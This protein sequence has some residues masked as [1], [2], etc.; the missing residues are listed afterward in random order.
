[1][2]LDIDVRQ[3]LSDR[4]V[5]SFRA[6]HFHIELVDAVL[7]GGGHLAGR[8]HR[9]RDWPGGNVVVRVRCSESWRPP[10]PRAPLALATRRAPPLRWVEHALW[11]QET[12]LGSLADAHWVPFDFELPEGLPPALEARSIAWR[13][14]IEARRCRRLRMSER[15]LLTPLRYTAVDRVPGHR[16]S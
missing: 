9:D 3:A 2:T 6:R 13:Y 12:R 7:E 10:L 5:A 14:E 1:V 16:I 8:V 15:A 11:E 4:M